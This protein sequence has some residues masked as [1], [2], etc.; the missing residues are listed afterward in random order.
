MSED[1]KNK[2]AERDENKQ[3][4]TRQELYDMLR[5]SSREEFILSEMKRLGFWEDDEGKPSL[6]E[7][8]IKKEAGL[9]K[10]LRELNARRRKME[11]LKAILKEMRSKRMAEAKA[12]REE[13][14]QKRA[15]EKKQR[16]EAF[17][18]KQAED[19]FYLGVGVSAGLHNIDNHVEQLAQNTY[20]YFEDIKALASAMHLDIPRL[21]YL[22]FHRK[23]S[24]VNHYMRFYV[25]KKTGGKRLISAPHFHLKKVQ[26]WILENI[27]YKR[28]TSDSAMGFVPGKS[29]LDNARPHTGA[30]VLINIDLKDFFP[31]IN[32]KRIKGMFANM[33]YSEQI[34]TVLAL[35][36]SE[37]EVDEVMMDGELF[38]VHKGLRFLP[39]GAPTSPAISNII[40]WK[41]DKRMEGIARKLDFTYT[42]YADDMSFSAS[43]EEAEKNMG[44]LL[45]V[46]KKIIAEEGFE[47]HPDKLRIMRKGSRKEVTGIVVNE[48][49]SVN[50]KK[51]RQF[52]ALLYQIEKE[53]PKGKTWG[54]NKGANLYNSIK[55]YANFV[56][57]VH[58]EKGAKFLEK[59]YRLKTAFY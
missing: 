2:Q 26:H 52:R 1:N 17:A 32:Y 33:G 46:V 45:F 54:N 59:V 55:G 50:R 15:E 3:P 28:Q 35:L 38:Y 11:N 31:T 23:V 19:I 7:I 39:Q 34:A 4:R 8:L 36:C 58:P 43:G 5:N 41:M 20:P 48:G 24:K 37:P 47:I 22:T 42:R 13:T 51:L 14:K 29:I 9:N 6:P 12:K 27:L 44:K 10:N 25:D 30:R 16:A 18:K 40:C 53:G 49:M 21:R 56:A 57:M